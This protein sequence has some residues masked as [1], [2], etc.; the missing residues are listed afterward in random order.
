M[1]LWE[2]EWQAEEGQRSEREQSAG[3]WGGGSPAVREEET[4]SE[5]RI[6]VN[7]GFPV[8]ET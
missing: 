1:A 5:G 3:S 2:G 4:G 7:T 6:V 8:R